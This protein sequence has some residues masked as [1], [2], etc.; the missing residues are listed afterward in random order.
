MRLGR[1]TR[2]AAR[3]SNRLP[4]LGRVPK[5][6][7]RKAALAGLQHPSKQWRWGRFVL[8]YPS[9]NPSFARAAAEYREALSDRS[10]FE[11]TTIEDLLA[12]PVRSNRAWSRPSGNASSD[13]SSGCALAEPFLQ[14]YG[15]FS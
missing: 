3:G 15:V 10:T 12:K 2:V 13:F 14:D 11:S 9:E 1:S 6:A 4:G 5:E 7:F 8:V